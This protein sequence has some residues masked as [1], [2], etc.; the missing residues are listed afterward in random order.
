M[1]SKTKTIITEAIAKPVISGI[2][3]A[4]AEYF[5]MGNQNVKKCAMFGGAVGVGIMAVSPVQIFVSPYFPT[6]TPMGKIGKILEGRIL[7]IACGASAAYALNR[8][9]LKNEYTNADLL[10]KLAIICAADIVG[11][12][13]CEVM[14]I[15]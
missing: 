13:A 9:V 8:F 1:V 11:E 14:L 7:E 5:I 3:A 12:T 2:T 15:V 4:A 10:Y 6:A